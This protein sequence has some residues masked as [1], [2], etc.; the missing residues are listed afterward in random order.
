MLA[1]S[2]R[3]LQLRSALLPEFISVTA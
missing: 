3:T 2:M 1:D